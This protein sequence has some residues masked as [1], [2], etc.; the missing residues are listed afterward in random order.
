[1]TFRDNSVIGNHFRDN[2]ADTAD[3]A[4]AGPTG[5]NVYSVAAVT[6]IVVTGN[7]I[8]DEAIG[9]SLNSPATAANAPPQLQAH[10]NVFDQKTIGISTLGKATVDGTLNWWGCAQGPGKDS[11]ATAT[12]G[13]VFTPWLV[14]KPEGDA[15]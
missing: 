15:W 1:V 6:G 8:E 2:G 10:L 7:V 9:V 5:I 11:C 14:Q 12:A 4:T 13:V 3:A